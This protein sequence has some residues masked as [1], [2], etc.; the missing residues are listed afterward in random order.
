[1]I[2][3]LTG[4]KMD[5][6]SGGKMRILASVFLAIFLLGHVAGCH[7]GSKA[8]AK[9]PA[10]AKMLNLTLTDVDGNK[11]DLR[12][13]YGKVVIM[14]FWD[15]WCGPCRREI[16]HFAALY[17]DYKDKDFVMVGV[18]FA[19]QGN[20]AVKKFGR[21]YGITYYNTIFNEDAARL[22]GRPPSIPTTFIIN[23]KGEVQQKVIGYRDRSFFENEINKLLNP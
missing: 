1:M 5:E 18:A 19:R 11:V 14:D 8:S 4:A 17:K 16:P 10:D 2:T 23:Q 7:P 12:Q 20:D 21:D 9:I 22:Y 13:F 3:L 6:D 15:T